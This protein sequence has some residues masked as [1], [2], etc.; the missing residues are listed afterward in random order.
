M[1]RDTTSTVKKRQTKKKLKNGRWFSLSDIESYEINLQCIVDLLNSSTTIVRHS[2][3]ESSGASSCPGYY[4]LNY[5]ENFGERI[6]K[7]Y[8]SE[9]LLSTRERP[10]SRADMSKCSLQTI[11]SSDI[12]SS[13]HSHNKSIVLD[14]EL[15]MREDMIF[16]FDQ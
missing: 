14:E 12:S 13:C 4:E 9:D 5:R 10:L 1:I 16:P 15:D 6:L 8:L 2:V 7:K 11:M 3:Y